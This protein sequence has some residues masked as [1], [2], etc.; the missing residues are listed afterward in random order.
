MSNGKRLG[1]FT[2][3]LGGLPARERYADAIR[4]IQRAEE[5][6]FE[7]AWIAQHH[8]NPDE[9]GLPAPLVFLAQ[10]GALTSRIRLGTGIITLPMEMALRVA[11]DCAVLDTLLDGRL[12]VGF[13]PGGTPGSFAAFGLDFADRR[14]IY[15]RN[16]ALIRAAWQGETL[17]G[18]NR[19]WPSAPELG[20]RIW[21]ATFSVEGAIRAGQA[22]DGL[23]LSRTQ[24]RPEGQETQ[25][26]WHIQMPLVEAYL[27]HLPPG[28]PPRIMASRSIYVAE[29]AGVARAH[30]ARGLRH[31][32]A[33]IG[34][35]RFRN[36]DRL[37]TDDLIQRFD[38]HVGTP[39]QVIASLGA[40][41]VLDHATDIAMQLHSADPPHGDTIRAIELFAQ[42]VAPALNWRPYPAVRAS[43]SSAQSRAAAI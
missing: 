8:F 18:D 20:A 26:L 25:P 31:A 24:P 5:L 36:L 29:D 21:Q 27:A 41:P 17:P 16:L 14:Q 37:T 43:T 22:G 23:M 34:G 9:G 39:D 11:E 7:T 30:T 35:A 3:L 6:G 13:G 42:D 19:I 33:R 1:F 2:R 40:D 38:Q 28:C 12:E 15:D 10:V 32:A 4:Q